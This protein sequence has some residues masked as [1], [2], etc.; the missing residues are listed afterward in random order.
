MT[1]SYATTSHRSI[2]L[3]FSLANVRPRYR[4]IAPSHRASADSSVDD[5]RFPRCPHVLLFA[6]LQNSHL[7]VPDPIQPIP[8][9]S[10]MQ[11]LPSSRQEVPHTPPRS[12]RRI[13]SHT[14][15]R[16]L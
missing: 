2:A 7:R 11:I 5:V 14:P 6:L 13:L 15:A 10:D 12:C 9:V 4:P 3:L 8:A 16:M 1:A